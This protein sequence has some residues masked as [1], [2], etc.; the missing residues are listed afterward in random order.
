MIVAPHSRY[1]PAKRKAASTPSATVCLFRESGDMLITPMRW[2]TPPRGR[3]VPPSGRVTFERLG[4]GRGGLPGRH[5]VDGHVTVEVGAE[6]VRP[7]GL[8]D[9]KST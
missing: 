7:A 5:Q 3:S 6:H 9:R 4:P 1:C 2:V 8:Q